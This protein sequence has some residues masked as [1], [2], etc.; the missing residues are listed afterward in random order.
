M[1]MTTLFPGKTMFEVPSSQPLIKYCKHYFE[2]PFAPSVS[3][4]AKGERDR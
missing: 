1:A 2:F 3:V 4:T